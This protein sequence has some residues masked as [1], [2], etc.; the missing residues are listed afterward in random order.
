M[1]AIAVLMVLGVPLAEAERRVRAAG[2][3]TERSAQEEALRRLEA[4][5]A[6]TP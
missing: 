5:L 2:S 6:P 3:G 4:F 1:A